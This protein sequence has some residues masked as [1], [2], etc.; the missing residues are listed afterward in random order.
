MREEEIRAPHSLVP[1][2]PIWRQRAQPFLLPAACLALIV[3]GIVWRWPTLGHVDDYDAYSFGHL[4]YS[5]VVKFYF[6]R[7]LP[8]H[9]SPYLQ[10]AIEYPVLT[11]LYIWFTAFVPTIQGYFLVSALL[12][13]VSLAVSYLLLGRI[14]AP[15]RVAR[16]ALAPGLILYGVLNWDALGVLGLSAAL[17]GVSRRRYGWAGAALAVGA[18][19]KLFPAF[20]LPVLLATLLRQRTAARDWRREPAVHLLAGVGLTAAVLNLPVALLSWHG[21]S[22]FLT[23]QSGRP[24]NP[25]AVWAHLPG[26]SDAVAGAVFLDGFLLGVLVLAYLVYRGARWEAA[27][28]LS[29]LLFLLLTRDYS[30]QYDLWVLPLLA[31]LACPWGLWLIFAAADLLY[32]AAIFWFYASFQG[33]APVGLGNPDQA[34]GLA[35]WG[36]EAALAALAVWAVSRLPVAATEQPVWPALLVAGRVVRRALAAAWERAGTGGRLAVWLLITLRVALGL[37]VALAPHRLPGKAAG[38][39][40]LNL[41]GPAATPFE[42]ILS[43]WQRWDALWYQHIATNGYGASNG[44]TAFYPLYPLLARLLA[45]FCGG[46]IVLAELLVASLAFGF[47]MWLLYVLTRRHLGPAAA[48]LTVLLLAFSPAGFFLLAPYTESLFLAFSLAA[49]WFAEQDRP[50]L[51]GLAGFGAGLTRLQGAFLVLP[52]AFLY[53]R[54]RDDRG[55]R[56]GLSV[57]SAALPPLGLIAFTLYQRLILG[58]SRSAVGTLSSWGIHIVP[59]WRT[60]PDSWQYIVQYHDIIEALNL[61]AMIGFTLLALWATRRLP[62]AY[63]LY[64][65][66]YLGL[67]FCREAF[68]PLSSDLRYLLVLFPCFMVAAGWLTRRPRLALGWLV[69]SVMVQVLLLEYWANWGFVA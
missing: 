28:L 64:V 53:F 48:L 16:F 44:T 35:V 17:Y 65:W 61:L 58:Q 8:A 15:D 68:S 57:I 52:L 23:F 54:R 31:V 10:Q 42:Q 18:S 45:V 14:A 60:L 26:V 30:P 27:A 2:W 13:G 38:G 34:L 21:W 62:L 51:A 67:L 9:H 59:P 32:F 12:L 7:D 37:V 63:A 1:T 6:T 19:A 40:W 43:S 46:N 36:R 39:A 11:G 47:A 66:P 29:L 69:V 50:W 49:F 25:D 5:D 56:P 4:Q 20:V 3:A 55:E 22:Y 24:I 41:I 33:S